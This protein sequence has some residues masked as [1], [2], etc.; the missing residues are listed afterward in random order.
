MKKT[1][2]LALLAAAAYGYYKYSKLTPT[3]KENLKMRG[4]DLL[5]K[6]LGLGNLFNNKQT[7]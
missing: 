2:G 3:E 6:K 5:D 4:K 1:L 7:V